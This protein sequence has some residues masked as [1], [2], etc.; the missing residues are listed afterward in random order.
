MNQDTTIHRPPYY[1]YP[2]LS[3]NITLPVA[4]AY[5]SPEERIDF[6]LKVIKEE[7]AR[8]FELDAAKMMSTTRETPHAQARMA[9]YYFARIQ[10]PTLTLREISRSFSDLRQ[11]HTTI[12]HACTAIQNLIDTRDA[13]YYDVL[14][15]I[16]AR[17]K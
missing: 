10:C 1:I 15:A 11:H 17:L 3:K 4:R 16:D 2:G 13:Q 6:I 12:L 8:H 14:M 5:F 7:F 9:Y